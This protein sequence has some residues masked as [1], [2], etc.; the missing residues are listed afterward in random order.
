MPAY[1]G[2]S[3][4]LTVICCHLRPYFSVAFSN[5]LLR[6]GLPLSRLAA[7]NCCL[8]GVVPAPPALRAQEEGK[9]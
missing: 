1:G 5:Q 9:A 7:E 8:Q 2:S 6:R 4:S 3:A